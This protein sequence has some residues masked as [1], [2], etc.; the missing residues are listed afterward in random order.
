MGV[1]VTT[2][3]RLA[4]DGDLKHVRTPG[5]HRRFA[6][7]DVAPFIPNHI[8]HM[9]IYVR[10]GEQERIH[11]IADL[12]EGLGKAPKMSIEE[13]S[14]DL[15][16]PLYSRPGIVRMAEYAGK[17]YIQGFVTYDKA[18]VGGYDQLRVLILMNKL[19]LQCFVTNGDSIERFP[20]I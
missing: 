8:S 15:T 11:R 1:H 20:N 6:L 19:G 7:S 13:R 3:R 5:G 16:R 12:L 10:Y 2:V 18:L 17:G 4:N 9:A 14:S